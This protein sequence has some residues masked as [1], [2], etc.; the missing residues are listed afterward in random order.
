MLYL[1]P[2]S[3]SAAADQLAGCRRR[4][5]P[6]APDDDLGHAIGRGQAHDGLDRHV[7]V[8][9][10]IAA[11]HQRA[12]AQFRHAVEY[13]L[14]EVFEVAR[15]LEDLDLLPQPGRAGAL[16]GQ[17]PSGKGLDLHDRA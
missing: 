16:A 10:A 13:R 15:L 2:K 12:A 8:V 14:H 1:M 3:P 11:Q 5:Q 7:V 9:A 6:V 17:G 4:Q